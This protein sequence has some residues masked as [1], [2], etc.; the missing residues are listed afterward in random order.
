MIIEYKIL[1]VIFS[2]V[3]AAQ[4]ECR[5]PQPRF[6]FNFLYDTGSTL[7]TTN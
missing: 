1:R 5:K 2:L 4:K 3:P 7:W 6:P